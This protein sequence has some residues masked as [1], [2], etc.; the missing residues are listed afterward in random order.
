MK[1]AH[2]MKQMFSIVTIMATRG[3]LTLS[4]MNYWPNDLHPHSG[5]KQYFGKFLIHPNE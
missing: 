4:Q 5:A 3:I 1:G 2:G